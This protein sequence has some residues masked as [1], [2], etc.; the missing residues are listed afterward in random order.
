MALSLN[1]LPERRRSKK[2]AT[3]VASPRKQP[4]QLPEY[5]FLGEARYELPEMPYELFDRTLQSSIFDLLTESGTAQL[6][7]SLV[8]D[9]GM[10]VAAKCISKSFRLSSLF[11]MDGLLSPTLSLQ[12]WRLPVPR[13]LV[14]EHR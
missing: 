8:R 14:T 11:S 6:S 1:E 9:I 12:R 5:R 13:F 2:S 3:K 4:W 10:E 7:P